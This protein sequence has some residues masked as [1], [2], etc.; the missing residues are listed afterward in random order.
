MATS[1]DPLQ[2]PSIEG[3]DTTPV[4]ISSTDSSTPV[5][6]DRVDAGSVQLPSIY[7]CSALSESVKSGAAKAGDMIL[8]LGSDDPSPVHLIGGPEERTHFDGYVIGRR[9]VFTTT[10]NGRLEFLPERDYDD[11]ECWEGFNYLISVPEVDD[12]IPAR[13]LLTRMAGR[14]ASKKLNYFIDRLHASPGKQQEPVPVRFSVGTRTNRK[15]Q[16]YFV[17]QTAGRQPGDDIAVAREMQ[18]YVRYMAGARSA[19]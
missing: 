3:S 17:V 4:V 14:I 12:M 10:A 13:F 18:Q 2:L 5:L 7:L 8:A 15:G 19:E 9:R 16:E 1:D 11:P 6:Y